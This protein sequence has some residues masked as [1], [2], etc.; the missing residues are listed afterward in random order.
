MIDVSHSALLCA[1]FGHAESTPDKTALV[2]G[3][4]RVSYS[5][6]V[7]LTCGSAVYLQSLGLKSGDRIL[8]SAQKEAEFIYLYAVSFR[9][10]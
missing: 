6:L 10:E 5:R 1:I 2:V 7:S 8:L 4:E 9:L 3:P